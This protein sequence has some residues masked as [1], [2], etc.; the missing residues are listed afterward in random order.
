LKTSAGD[1]LPAEFYTFARV[2]EPDIGHPLPARFGDQIELLGYDYTISNVVHAAHTPAVVTTYWHALQP[3]SATTQLVLF[4]SRRD[5]AIVYHYEGSTAATEWLPIEMWSV[6]DVIRV[7]T[8]ALSVGRL[9]EAMVAVV[10]AQGDL[11][12]AEDRLAAVSIDD[13]RPIQVYEQGTLLKL[14]DLP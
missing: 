11:W 8:P 10:P 12:S 3:L 4:F 14:F 7:Q 1:S 2:K 13:T 5:G 9:K 6:G